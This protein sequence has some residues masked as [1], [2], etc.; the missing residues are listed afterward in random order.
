MHDPVHGSREAMGEPTMSR[1]E[2]TPFALLTVSGLLAIAW[3]FI[4]WIRAGWGDSPFSFVIGTIL[5]MVV[6]VNNQ[7]RWMLLAAM[8]RPLPRPAPPGLRL[9]LVTTCVPAVEPIEMLEATLRAMVAVD[10]P[11]DTWLLDEGNDTALRA[12]CDRLGVRHFSRRNIPKYQA[13]AGTFRRRSKHGNYNAWLDHTGFESYDYLIAFD[14]DHLPLPYYADEVLGY[15]DHPD[16]GYVQPAQ[17]FY[18]QQAS[19]IARGAAEETYAYFSSV[20]MAAY[21]LGYP[22]IVGSHNAHRMAALREV[23]GF[24]AHDADDLLL[25]LRYQGAG[26]AGVYVPKVLARGLAPVD[27]QGYLIQQRRWARSVLDIKLRRWDEVAGDLALSAR[28][29][30]FLHGINFLHRAALFVGVI[31]LLLY[32]LAT[33]QTMAVLD[34]ALIAPVATLAVLLAVQESFRQRFYLGREERGLHWR[35]A[36]LEFAKW[37]WFTVALLDVVATRAIPYTITRK[38]PYARPFVRVVELNAGLAGSIILAWLIGQTHGT[39]G[40]ASMV[41]GSV[42]VVL[43]LVVIATVFVPPPPPFQPGLWHPDDEAA[44]VTASPRASDPALPRA[45]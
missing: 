21:A 10:Y 43:S 18:N 13:D 5:I 15:F 44:A 3:F 19:F 25:T 36:L 29:M 2:R 17:A 14:P 23:G 35:S 37:P 27:W 30:S 38:T 42:F 24:A 26:W 32:L 45:T 34:P 11:H 33:A 22:I 8:R 41:V 31:A 39:P 12:L 7:G 28:V 1:S 20:Q 16:I 6:L 9:A 40:P 4:T